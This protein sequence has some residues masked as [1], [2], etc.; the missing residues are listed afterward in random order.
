MWSRLKRL[1]KAMAEEVTKPAVDWDRLDG[2]E[3]DWPP[4]KK[5]M[6]L[7]PRCDQM[8]PRETFGYVDRTIGGEYSP[9]VICDECRTP[10]KPLTPKPLTTPYDDREKK[11]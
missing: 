7:C 2:T 11:A 10:S 8:R 3:P 9:Q 5:A 1:L 4:H 6:H